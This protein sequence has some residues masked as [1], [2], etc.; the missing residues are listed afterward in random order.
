[1]VKK[2][3]SLISQ[4]TE[5]LYARLVYKNLKPGDIVGGE[6]KLA[7]DFGVSR[8]TMREAANRLRGLGIITGRQRLGLIVQQP[9]LFKQFER[10][11]PFLADNEVSLSELMDFR[12]AL[13][14]GA[15]PLVIERITETQLREIEKTIEPFENCQNEGEL[16]ASIPYDNKFH[17]LLLEASG[18]EYL[19]RLHEIVCLYFRRLKTEW[20]NNLEKESSSTDIGEH[21][22]LLAA[23]RDKDRLAAI[24]IIL[25]H[26]TAG[27]NI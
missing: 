22:K 14:M 19:S 12:M 4:L 24:E 10:I 1:M 17:T 13:E 23:I 16:K 11:L 21:R 8:G 18:N 15:V 9:V 5:R 7:A 26:L 27:R 3:G 25:R 6:R 20:V 2:S